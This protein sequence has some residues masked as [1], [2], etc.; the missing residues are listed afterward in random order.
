LLIEGVAI[1]AV[2][3]IAKGPEP[4]QADAALSDELAS[5]EKPVEVLVI[6]EK[7]QNT[8]T[9][10]SYLYDTEIYVIIRNKH[11]DKVDETIQSMQAQLSTEIATIFRR[12]EPAYM[13]EPDLATLSRQVGAVLVQ[14]LGVDSEGEP[15]VMGT[16]IKK[17][18]RI[19]ADM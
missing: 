4:I 19:R 3:M 12:A 5:A 8:R 16:L 14:K 11:M 9:G 17:C 6:Q 1:A 15:Y 13:M 7:F 2:F 10:R 18:I